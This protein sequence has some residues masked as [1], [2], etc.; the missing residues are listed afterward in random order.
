MAALA[1]GG[2]GGLSVRPPLFRDRRDAGRQLA[3]RLGRFAGQDAL[4][5]ALPR[6]GV[7]VGFE[8]AQA[9]G[10]GLDVLVARKL[11]VPGHP[12][13]A[14]GAV[15]GDEKVLEDGTIAALA[16]PKRDLDRVEAEERLEAAR[17]V[18]LYRGARP[19][20]QVE[21]RVVI[22]VDDGVATGST[23]KAALRALRKKGPRLLVFA[24]PV[25][26][27]HAQRELEGEADQVEIVATPHLFGAVG[28]W[29]A[30]FGQTSD[31]EVLELL[32]AARPNPIPSTAQ[33]SEVA[34]PTGDDAIAAT[35]AVPPGARG[36]VVFAHGSGS[37]RHSVRNRA[38][39]ARLHA[40]GFATVLAD[41]L[42]GREAAVDERTREHRFDIPLLAR[43]L[44]DVLAW[45]RGDGLL[46]PLPVGLFGSSTGAAAALVAAAQERGVAAVVSRGGRPDLAGDLLPKVH[47]PT[48][49]L[50]GGRDEEVLELNRLAQRRLGGPARLEVVAGA[51]HLF[52]EPGA[53]EEVSRHAADW[54]T[55]HLGGA[56]PVRPRRR[57]RGA[58]SGVEDELR[59]LS[60]PLDDAGLDRLVEAVG[61]S[62]IVLLG[63]ATH[64]T[65]EFYTWRARL[66]MRLI[67][68]H[69]F[70]FVAVEG[71]WPDCFRLNRFVKGDPAVPS[72][73][74]TVLAEFRRWPTW[75]WAN[76]EVAGFL[77]ELRMLNREVGA[78]TDA[79]AGFYGLDVYSLWESL[80][81]LSASLKGRT[82]AA[83]AV[84]AA[85]R[86]FEPYHED[87]QAYASTGAWLPS[88]CHSQ[89]LRA[90]V[91]TRS[92]LKALPDSTTEA[93][94]DA[95]QNALVAVNAEAYYRAMV[96]GGPGSWNLRD[97]HMLDTLGRLLD[98]HGP[99]AKA[100]VWAHNTHVGDA[101]AT[102]MAD[103]GMVNLGQL[104]RER[105]PGEV[106]AV[107]FTTYEGEVIAG[108]A[109]E[110]P[111]RRLAVP[112]AR[113]GSLERALHGL[114]G[115]RV[116]LLGG[117]AHGLRQAIPHRAIGVVYHPERESGN[118]VPTLVPE[119]Y[120]AL[121]HV[122][123]S[124]AVSPL[125][126][127][128]QHEEPPE[129]FPSGV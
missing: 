113:E 125:H 89:V 26:P 27:L 66:S 102:D 106:S 95:E 97:T 46:A 71:D 3:A 90:L 92:S 55:Q 105:W 62:R 42:T 128:V 31:D 114:G 53:L 35:V 100:I 72:D 34:I 15:A 44:R 23:A 12:E 70:R 84:Q 60:F 59:R 33:G 45:S 63:E 78:R 14:F 21:G 67:R 123:R 77:S 88:D 93:R 28:H 110:A 29:Y 19:D 11:G 17:R 126:V 8:V 2:P 81:A 16:I 75:M 30:D 7:P 64:G 79:A 13:L 115:D 43:R 96:L 82:D 10:G 56:R 107:G 9:V 38:V 61:P 119:R 1:D 86:C 76:R 103:A 109:W 124:H 120:D 54:F 111:M 5:L 112:P 87:G 129:T 52:E 80:R 117:Q 47:A 57:L 4:V 37:G 24:A 116:V 91:E 98:H 22:L 127:P 48:L 49:L 40:H 68:E 6:G 41:L 94:L 25:G 18:R 99:K 83:R 69:G 39:A 108:Q 58:A 73:A 50:V 85:L 65:R 104:A 118:Y 74:E 32:Q 122:D 121:V 101:R 20:P 36:L 51:T